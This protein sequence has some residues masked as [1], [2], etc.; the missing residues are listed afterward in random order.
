M[1][2]YMLSFAFIGLS[3]GLMVM[4]CG[5]D[6]NNQTSSST[7][8]SSGMSSQPVPLENAAAAYAKFFCEYAFSCCDM[9]ELVG[10]FKELSQMP[11]TQA[12]CEPLATARVDPLVF[13]P[14]KEAVAAGRLAYDADKAG[15]CFASATVDCSKRF[16]K[17]FGPDP[18]CD[19][20]FTGKV[21][22][23]GDC[24]QD[25]ECA[26]A[27][28]DCSGMVGMPGK[29]AVLPKE[30]DPCPDG[31]CQDGLLCSLDA[32]RICIKPKADGMA[33]SL[34]FECASGYCDSTSKCAAKKANGAMCDSPQTCNDGYCDTVTNLCTARKTVGDA[35]MDS[36]QCVSDQ[37]DT[38][39]NKCVPPFCDGM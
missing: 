2:R 38:T 18:A 4:G 10:I 39:M 1:R 31:S 11:K 15:I 6:T 32:T 9:T 36:D 27:G 14:L 23:G 26:Q 29:C 25:L 33:C 19:T 12:E 35:C 17:E 13:A 20:V 21:A 34:Y 37:C 28:S 3:A 24:Q 7:G 8:T 22:D 30:N 16:P 5:S